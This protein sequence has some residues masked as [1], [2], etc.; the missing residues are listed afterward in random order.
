VSS[1][2]LADCDP[3]SPFDQGKALMETL[4]RREALIDGDLPWVYL[5]H[6]AGDQSLEPLI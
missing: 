5:G 4:S 2:Q 3:L 6:C 1:P